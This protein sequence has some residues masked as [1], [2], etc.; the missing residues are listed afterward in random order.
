MSD[1][2]KPDISLLAPDEKDVYIEKLERALSEVLPFVADANSTES[3]SVVAWHFDHADTINKAAA[4]QGRSHLL[5][6]PRLEPAVQFK[7]FA[8]LYCSP[9][10]ELKVRGVS[11]EVIGPAFNYDDVDYFKVIGRPIKDLGVTKFYVLSCFDGTPDELDFHIAKYA[12]TIPV[13]EIPT[14]EVID[15]ALTDERHFLYQTISEFLIGHKAT[16]F[17][18]P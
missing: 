7:F 13:D 2:S 10:G 16:A 12:W 5:A 11:K 3:P 15:R 4:S 1:K 17:L 8:V 9:T 6:H 14:Y 18:F